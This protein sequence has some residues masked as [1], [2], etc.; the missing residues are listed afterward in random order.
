M[1]HYNYA[2]DYTVEVFVVHNGT[3]L[4]RKHDKYGVWLSVGGHIDPGE[5]PLEAG[6]REVKEEVGLDVRINEELK[7]DVPSNAS[8]TEL[9]PPRFM[10]RHAVTDTHE[11]L[12]FIFFATSESTN[13]V[14]EKETDVWKWVSLEELESMRDELL[15][16][17]YHHARTALKEVTN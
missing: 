6:V 17:V 7:P 5:D 16:S 1:A 13:I 11:H 8:Y 14:P 9:T 15:P 10:Y 4:L 2:L 3:V 12:A